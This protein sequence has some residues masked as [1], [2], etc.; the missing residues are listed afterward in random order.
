MFD[1]VSFTSRGGIYDYSSRR[2]QWY[3]EART[4]L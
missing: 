3:R 2:R 1:E 4:L